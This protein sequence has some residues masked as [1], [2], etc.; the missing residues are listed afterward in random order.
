MQPPASKKSKRLQDFHLW[1]RALQISSERK[2]LGARRQQQQERVVATWS[3]PSTSTLS[4]GEAKAAGATDVRL[5][6]SKED[7]EQQQQERQEGTQPV[8]RGMCKV[9]G[10]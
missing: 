6:V 5:T 8:L 2:K 1:H 3:T 9:M 10:C 4:S 7:G